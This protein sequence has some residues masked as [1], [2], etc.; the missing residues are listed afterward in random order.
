MALDTFNITYP[1]VHVGTEKSNI[2]F[3]SGIPDLI[4]VFNPGRTE[5]KKRFFVT[6]ATVASLDCMKDFIA[7]FDDDKCG[8]DMLIIL[9]SGEPYKTLESVQ[10][11]ISAAVDGEFTRK[12]IFVGIG[13]GVICDITAFA[14]SLFKRGASVQFVPTT[15]LAMVDAS[16][17]GKC[18][19]DFDNYKNMIGTFFP[20]SDLYYWPEFVQYLPQNQFSSGLA[21]AF[22]TGILYDK[23]LFDIFK[24]ESEKIN[25]R[26]SEILYK[27]IQKCVKAKAKVVEQDFTEQNIRA[28]L[29]LGHTFGHALES[30]AGLGAITHGEAV[31]WGIGRAVAVSCNKGYCMQAF[32]QEINSLL[33]LYNWETNAIPSEVKGGGV[34]ERFLTVM[35]K[36]KKNLN[37]KIRLIIPKAVADVVIEEVEEADILAVIK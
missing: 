8:N 22:K 31:A 28:L 2:N 11:I 5:G 25:N 19:C 4:S 17:G 6:D 1:S 24:T 12:D 9:G 32:V 29:N 13:G 30:I 15:L 10:R 36:D 33:E 20:A 3:Y 14:A 37:S 34:G 18:G 21:E 35:H 26:D 7:K 16:I 23:E 27:I